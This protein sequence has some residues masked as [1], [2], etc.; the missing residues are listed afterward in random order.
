MPLPVVTVPL[1]LLPRAAPRPNLPAAS[2]VSR[3]SL[4]GAWLGARTL[5]WTLLAALSQHAPPLD[6][7]EWLCWGRECSWAITSIPPWPPGWADRLSPTRVL[8]SASIWWAMSRSLGALACVWTVG[9]R[10]LP[11]QPSLAATVCLD[12]LVFFQ[13]AAAGVQQPGAAHRLLGPGRSAVPT[14]R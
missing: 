3:T 2:R 11:P 13:Q 14:P 1:P 6:T 8:S 12:G 10:M 5:L 4:F 7:V 9:R